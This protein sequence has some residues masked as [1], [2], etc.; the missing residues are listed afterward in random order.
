MYTSYGVWDGCK[1]ASSSTA[2]AGGGNM[3]HTSYGAWDASKQASSG[4]A[5]SGGDTK[6]VIWQSLWETSFRMTMVVVFNSPSTQ[7]TGLPTAALS[8][9]VGVLRG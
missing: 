6:S 8:H 5:A 4:T 3:Q 7:L 2:A 9:R 1:E